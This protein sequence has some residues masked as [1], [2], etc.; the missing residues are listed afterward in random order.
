MAAKSGPRQSTAP[1]AC[2]GNIFTKLT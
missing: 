2:M 1:K